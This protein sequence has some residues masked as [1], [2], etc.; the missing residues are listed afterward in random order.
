[1]HLRQLEIF[2]AVMA[3]GTTTGAAIALGISQP[4]V[5]RTISNAEHAL[6]LQLFERDRGRLIPT[7]EATRLYQEIEP[8]F[9]SLEAAQ[10]RIRDIRD[11]K[12][13][14]IRI[15]AT[16]SLANSIVPPAINAIVASTPEVRISLDVRRW[17]NLAA[18]VESNTADVGLVLTG[19]ERPTLVAKPLYEGRMVCV[20]PKEHP[21]A[22][23]PVIRP[24][25]F[26]G[27]PFVRLS[28]ASPLGDLISDAF[29]TAGIELR[30]VIQTRYCNIVCALVQSGIGIGMVDEFVVTSGNYPGIVAR[31][32]TPTIPLTAYAL[33]ARHRAMS[34]LTKRFI[35]EVET[36]FLNVAEREAAR[37]VESPVP[38][39]D[40]GVT[41]G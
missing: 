12:T 16:P 32:F 30:T 36:V 34:R 18:Q 28:K 33:V 39:V 8:L 13:G 6:G 25:H 10:A 11:G 14:S 40:A 21:L 27:Q 35:G 5:S 31:P 38:G 26:D 1:M 4:A 23:E 15:V 7:D 22:G 9:M 19:R 3:S 37:S 41:D 17:E 29:E 24:G 20:L 2:R